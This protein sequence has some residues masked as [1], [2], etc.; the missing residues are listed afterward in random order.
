MEHTAS[1]SQP[2]SM[3]KLRRS[4]ERS[5]NEISASGDFCVTIASQEGATVASAGLIDK[6]QKNPLILSSMRT[7]QTLSGIVYGEQNILDEKVQKV[8]EDPSEGHKILQEILSAPESVHKF[9]GVKL[10][11]FKSRKRKNALESFGHL[12]DAIGN[13]IKT[14]EHARRRATFEIPPGYYEQPMQNSEAVEDLLE[15]FNRSL[16]SDCSSVSKIM[17]H[18]LKNNL[19]TREYADNIRYLCVRVYGYPNVLEKEI[20]AM[21]ELPGAGE[22]VIDILINNPQSIHS[23]AGI[24]ICGIK[25]KAR[26]NAELGVWDLH[27]SVLLFDSIVKS[28]R[29]LLTSEYL[30]QQKQADMIQNQTPETAEQNVCHTRTEPNLPPQQERPRRVPSE[31]MAFAL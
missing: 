12:C 2:L 17:S 13:L 30:E 18:V 16:K 3:A 8:L 28:A 25:N 22:S 10:C 14:V 9:S 15:S 27:N 31:R 29:D 1:S 5:A 20:S 7:I 24:E 21:C 26:I 19:L 11:G 4:S 6:L 23:F